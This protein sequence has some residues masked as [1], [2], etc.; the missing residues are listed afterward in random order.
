MERVKGIEPSLS[1]WEADNELCQKGRGCRGLG[2]LFQ[3]ESILIRRIGFL[4]LV[5]LLQLFASD[6][7]DDVFRKSGPIK[8]AK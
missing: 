8:S 6:F 1:A 5:F 7:F 4:F 2:N 3:L